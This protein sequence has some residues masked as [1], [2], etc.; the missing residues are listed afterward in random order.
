MGEGEGGR[1]TSREGLREGRER[2]ERRERGGEREGGKGEQ[3]RYL[4][5]RRMGHLQRQP[6]TARQQRQKTDGDR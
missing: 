6:S 1:E 5:D 4:S 2:R 3:A